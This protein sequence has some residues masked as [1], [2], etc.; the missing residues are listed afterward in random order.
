[1]PNDVRTH[2]AWQFLRFLTLKNSG[3][4]TLYNGVTKNSKDFP[5]NFDPATDYLKRTQQP[6]ARRD[7]IESQKSDSNLGPF[8]AGNLIAKHWYQVEPDAVDKIF[9]DMI[10]SVN[11]G[12]VTLHEA[13]SLAKN[14]IN[15]SSGSSTL[16]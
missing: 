7:I 9:T 4:I 14:K 11:R 1:V 6:A 5:I 16:R 8:A 12:D 3:T 2:E 10:E 13:L 15:Y